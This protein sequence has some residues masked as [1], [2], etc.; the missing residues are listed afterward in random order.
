V[1]ILMTTTGAKIFGCLKGAA[2]A[3]LFIPHNEKRFP[4]FSCEDKKEKYDAKIHRDRI[5][6][7]HI[8]KYMKL[9]KDKSKDAFT[10]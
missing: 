8:D 7:A 2:D 4:G 1:G 9:L 10:K 6:G 3:G 5:M